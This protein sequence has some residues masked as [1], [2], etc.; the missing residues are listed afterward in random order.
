MEERCSSS[1][2]FI[3]LSPVQ[4]KSFDFLA[5]V[6][7]PAICRAVLRD[8]KCTRAQTRGQF[9]NGVYKLISCELTFSLRFLAV[10]CFSGLLSCSELHFKHSFMEFGFVVVLYLLIQNKLM[11]MLRKRNTVTLFFWH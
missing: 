1:L 6:Q 2:D 3:Y 7:C 4:L 8:L 5:V 10:Y 9:R 11:E